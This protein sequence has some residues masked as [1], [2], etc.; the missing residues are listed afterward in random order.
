MRRAVSL[1]QLSYL[2]VGLLLQM[3]KPPKTVTVTDRS[4]RTLNVCTRSVT[5]FD[6]IISSLLLLLR[7]LASCDIHVTVSHDRTCISAFL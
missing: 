4:P 3:A 2:Y 1:P 5:R 6:S 7:D